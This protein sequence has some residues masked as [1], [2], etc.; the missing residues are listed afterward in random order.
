MI[1]LAHI[2]HIVK[3]ILKFDIFW[4]VIFIIIIGFESS[5]LQKLIDSKGSNF[6]WVSDVAHSFI[7]ILHAIINSISC[8]NLKCLFTGKFWILFKSFEQLSF[9]VFCH[10]LDIPD[11][12]TFT[13]FF[14]HL[15]KILIIDNLFQKL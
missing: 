3:N 1:F 8:T 15:D 13:K 4:S 7:E 10:K 9:F 12:G 11:N 5:L 14:F 2:N 6:N